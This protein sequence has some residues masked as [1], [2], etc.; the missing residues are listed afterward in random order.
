MADICTI[1]F[2]PCIDKG[3][4]VNALKPEGTA[5]TLNAG[6]SLCKK[7]NVE[8]LYEQIS[9]DKKRLQTELGNIYNLQ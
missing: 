2:N 6:T 9:N 7:E 5:A 4:S 1:T 3:T 8:R